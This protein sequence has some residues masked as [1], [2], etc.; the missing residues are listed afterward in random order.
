MSVSRPLTESQIAELRRQLE[1]LE[2]KA[3]QA[4][5][6]VVR[7][8][9]V[10]KITQIK[11]DLGET[12]A[13]SPSAATPA[14]KP[15][16]V[17]LNGAAQGPMD[18]TAVQALL[19]AKQIDRDTR[20]WTDGMAAWAPL[21][22]FSEFAVAAE[23]VEPPSPVLETPQSEES[24]TAP[25]PIEAEQRPLTA[26]EKKKRWEDDIV[27]P[28]P[29]SPEQTRQADEF[30]RLARI[31][32]M[33]GN[34]QEYARLFGQAQQVAPGAASVLEALGDDLM[35]RKNAGEARVAYFKAHRM[36]PKNVQIER[37]YAEV[38][39]QLSAN[40]SWQTQMLLEGEE[41]ENAKRAAVLSA[42]VPGVGQIVLGQRVKGGVMT[43]IW[44][45]CILG[46]TI[47]IKGVAGHGRPSV[48]V[49]GMVVVFIGNWI[50]AIADCTKKTKGKGDTAGLM[51]Y[52]SQ[53]EGA[54]ARKDKKVHP[55][56][57][58]NLPFE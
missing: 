26:A 54:P 36:A 51:A 7:D 46:I 8:A 50:Y 20:V 1:I 19:A 52:M 28:S 12:P 27:L 44:L 16:H 15:Y 29:A 24:E 9:L 3:A 31:A 25:E 23:P 55:I 35:D 47:Y 5:E 6:P 57:P 48:F 22:E 34:V 33:R 10:N 11:R 56:P 14:S 58:E 4:T 43:A 53:G 45:F 38:V 17:F 32:K 40:S 21:S 13:A 37:K 39:F 49:V 30:L 42:F 41:V 2:S 18:A